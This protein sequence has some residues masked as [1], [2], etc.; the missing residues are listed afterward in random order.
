MTTPQRP[1]KQP[2]QQ[3]T[4][5]KPIS[6][7]T[8]LLLTALDTT[9]RAFVPTIGGLFLGIGIDNW[10]GIKPFATIGCMILGFVLSAILIARQLTAVQRSKT[11]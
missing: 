7:S 6:G 3:S 2:G 10:L 5:S 11:Q 4:N 1:T 9:W 8:V